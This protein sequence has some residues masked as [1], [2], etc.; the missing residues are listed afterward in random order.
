MYGIV[1]VSVGQGDA[2]CGSSLNI[3]AGNISDAFP[4]LFNHSLPSCFLFST[5][6]SAAFFFFFL[7]QFDKKRQEFCGGGGGG[8]STKTVLK[9]SPVSAN[10]WLS[11]SQWR[12]R[13]QLG[14]AGQG[15]R[16]NSYSEHTGAEPQNAP[17]PTPTPKA[18]VPVL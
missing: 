13:R 1:C 17:P 3:L 8:G 11:C 7:S 4:S 10:P 15:T 2:S 18:L 5:S 14:M 16:T 9:N 12:S 6:F